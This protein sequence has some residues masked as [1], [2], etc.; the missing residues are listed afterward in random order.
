MQWSLCC[1][2]WQCCLQFIPKCFHFAIEVTAI[3]HCA[4]AHM[5]LLLHLLCHWLIVAIGNFK[6]CCCDWNPWCHGGCCHWSLCLCCYCHPY[7]HQ[8]CS[9]SFPS[10]WLH[11]IAA[12][13]VCATR[14]IK[15][16]SAESSCWCTRHWHHFPV[17]NSVAAAAMC[18]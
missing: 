12:V 8:C 16:C 6:S 2:L 3:T 18:C 5:L 11:G 10:P 14:P 9:S 7:H 1:C 4:V 15:L 13:G 17:L